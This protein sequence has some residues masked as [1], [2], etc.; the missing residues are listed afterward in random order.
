[1]SF[2]NHIAAFLPREQP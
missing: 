2:S 1:M